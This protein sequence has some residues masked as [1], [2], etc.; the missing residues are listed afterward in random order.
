MNKKTI[1]RLILA[2]IAAV[3]F[4]ASALGQFSRT[5][6]IFRPCSGSTTPA[7]VRVTVAGGITFAPCSGQATTFGGNITGPTTFRLLSGANDYVQVSNSVGVNLY[8]ATTNHSFQIATVEM[9]NI[10]P[11]GQFAFNRTV[12]AAGTTGNQ[13]INKSMGTVNVAAGAG[14][15][16]LT[17]TS[18][19]ATTS[20]II[21]AVAQTN[22]ATCAVK[23][24]VPGSG[25]FVIRMTAN[26]TAET[27]VGFWVT[28]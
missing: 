16:G 25:S 14:A 3:I 8:S 10:G 24:A 26:C 19:I 13:T 2:A 17:V 5:N 28:N 15:A 6:Q 18:S 9:F 27:S 23:N 12:T 4:T 1:Y 22:D 7:S 11:L 21:F 20:S